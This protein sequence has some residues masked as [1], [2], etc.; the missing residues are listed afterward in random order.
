M[1]IRSSGNILVIIVIMKRPRF[2][3][4]NLMRQK[5]KSATRRKAKLMESV[6]KNRHWASINCSRSLKCLADRLEREANNIVIGLNPDDL[7]ID[8]EID[9][10]IKSCI[11]ARF[12]V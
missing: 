11:G 2:C 1:R 3:G 8:V 6:A 7:I 10:R 5:F 4:L 12:F 9:F